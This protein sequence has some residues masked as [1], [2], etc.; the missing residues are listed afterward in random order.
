[1]RKEY[2][3]WRDVLLI[4]PTPAK[5]QKSLESLVVTEV[6]ELCA[7]ESTLVARRFYLSRPLP[8]KTRNLSK[9]RMDQ[10]YQHLGYGRSSLGVEEKH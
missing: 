5:D 3:G 6:V 1:V 10:S 4:S 9:V 8:H 2:S 7:Q